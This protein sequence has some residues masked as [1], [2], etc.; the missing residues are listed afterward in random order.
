MPIGSV[1]KH[2]RKCHKDGTLNLILSKQVEYSTYGAL[3]VHK[4]S[5]RQD[6]SLGHRQKR[7][8]FSNALGSD[9][10][11][12]KGF[13]KE[14]EYNVFISSEASLEKGKSFSFSGSVTQQP[15]Q[16]ESQV[17]NSKVE[18]SKVFKGDFWAGKHLTAKAYK[19]R[20]V[21]F[22]TS[23]SSKDLANANEVLIGG[24][25]FLVIKEL[26]YLVNGEYCIDKG[27]A[28]KMLN[29]LMYKLC[30]YRFGEAKRGQQWSIIEEDC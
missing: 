20:K 8:I 23:F 26:D 7:A 18:R 11:H 2:G 21:K 10:A 9:R 24:G 14:Q 29:F 19:G 28:P 3:E 15:S 16:M 22:N 5:T 13:N 6:I 17:F 4:K 27:V 1:H 12:N 25:V 30:Y